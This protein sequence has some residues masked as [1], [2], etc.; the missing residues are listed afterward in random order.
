MAKKGANYVLFDI[1]LTV[2]YLTM[3]TA[4]GCGD[5]DTETATASPSEMDFDEALWSDP[6]VEYWPYV[7]WW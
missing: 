5:G 4:L 6:P 7:R 1:L 3:I 2:L